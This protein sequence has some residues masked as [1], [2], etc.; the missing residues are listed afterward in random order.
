VLSA[1]F[2]WKRLVRWRPEWIEAY[3]AAGELYCE[4]G[5]FPEAKTMLMQAAEAALARERRPQGA[6]AALRK[7]L[8]FDPDDLRA[9]GKLADLC[10]ELG[11][12]DE[13]IEQLC[14]IA[15][16]LSQQG[17]RREAIQVIELGLRKLGDVATLRS[18]LVEAQR[19]RD[20]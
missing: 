14:A 2:V 9:R 7:I 1:I 18:R 3:V 6:A 16:R 8:A 17:H 5:L 12:R 4:I 11:N 13:S 15:D 19:V 10:L 20:E